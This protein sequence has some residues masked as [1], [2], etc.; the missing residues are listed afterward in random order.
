VSV[1]SDVE[2]GRY[3]LLMMQRTLTGEEQIELDA[4]RKRRLWRFRSFR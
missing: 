4:L 3:Q 2:I 1:L